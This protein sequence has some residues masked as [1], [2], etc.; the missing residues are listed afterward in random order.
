[1]TQLYD[2]LTLHHFLLN[3]ICAAS[4]ARSACIPAVTKPE[5]LTDRS[6]DQGS[7]SRD[8][9]PSLKAQI[10]RRTIIQNVIQELPNVPERQLKVANRERK[11]RQK[12]ALTRV[13]RL[14]FM[15]ELLSRPKR[16]GPREKGYNAQLQALS[17][18]LPPKGVTLTGPAPDTSWLLSHEVVTG[19]DEALYLTVGEVQKLRGLVKDSTYRVNKKAATEQM[20]EQ[21][22]TRPDASSASDGMPVSIR[23]LGADPL[24][25]STSRTPYSP[26]T[27]DASTFIGADPPPVVGLDST[28]QRAQLVLPH[29]ALTPLDR[30]A[31]AS[32]KH[33]ASSSQLEGPHEALLRQTP[34]KKFRLFGKDFEI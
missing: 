18:Y 3:R 10:E 8:F 6:I 24:V 28:S 12:Q 22:G 32:L 34:T 15:D 14:D 16:R 29:T 11:A 21:F 25:A 1:M 20:P 26:S 31:E 23:V 33:A 17:D 9:V 2:R 30:V 27:L 5:S 7:L 4:L 19:G 13:P